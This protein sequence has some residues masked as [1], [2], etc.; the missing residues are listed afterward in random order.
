MKQYGNIEDTVFKGHT[1]LR[2]CVTVTQESMKFLSKIC[3]I[4]S[5]TNDNIYSAC[6]GV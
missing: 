3:V 4:A 2:K 6:T 5:Y 1:Q